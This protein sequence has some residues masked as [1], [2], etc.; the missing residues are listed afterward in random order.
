MSNYVITP[1]SFAQVKEFVD[2][3]HRHNS[4]PHGH[5]FSIGL[6]QND[7]LIGVISVGRPVARALDNGITAEVTRSCVLE[8][9]MNANSMLYGAA[10]RASQAMGYKKM[11]TYTQADEPGSS[12]KA[13]GMRKVADLP[14]RG[15]W[16]DSSK[17]R[18]RTIENKKDTANVARQRWEIP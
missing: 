14:P 13:I 2:L 9:H 12:L 5:K 18:I 4:A 6:K 17:K 7:K 8:G 16:A 1:V 10:W 3:Y 11:I 15:N